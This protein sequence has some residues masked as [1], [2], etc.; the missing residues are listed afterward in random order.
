MLLFTGILQFLR[1]FLY[2]Y[3][4]RSK[5]AGTNQKLLKQVSS[6][7]CSNISL[8]STYLRYFFLFLLHTLIVILEIGPKLLQNHSALCNEICSTNRNGSIGKSLTLTKIVFANQKQ[9]KK[10]R[11]TLK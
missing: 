11:I 1:S 5:F 3:S 10:N 2:I 8:I 6:T 9:K 4:A 7:H